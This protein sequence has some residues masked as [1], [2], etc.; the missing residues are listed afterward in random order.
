MAA[1]GQEHVYA[2]VHDLSDVNSRQ[3]GEQ[4]RPKRETMI[5]NFEHKMGWMFVWEKLELDVYVPSVL[6]G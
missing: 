4:H 3:I 6:V 5:F 1:I 2:S